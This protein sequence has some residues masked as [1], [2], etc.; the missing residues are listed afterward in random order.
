MDIASSDA[1]C[2]ACGDAYGVQEALLLSELLQRVL[3]RSVF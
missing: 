2:C 3:V 1:Y